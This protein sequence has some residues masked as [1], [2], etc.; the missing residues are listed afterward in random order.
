MVL[1]KKKYPTTKSSDP[2]KIICKAAEII[3]KYGWIQGLFQDK[4]TGA[5]C[6]VG[7]IRAALSGDPTVVGHDNMTRYVQAKLYLIENNPA[8]FTFGPERWN[9][10]PERSKEEVIEVLK[11]TCSVKGKQ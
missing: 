3:E 6:L 1:P 7:G 4:S 8:M 9:D 10:S 11:A 2:R 5:V